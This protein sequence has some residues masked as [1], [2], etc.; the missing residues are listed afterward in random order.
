LGEIKKPYVPPVWLTKPDPKPLL[1]RQ[2]HRQPPSPLVLA[3]RRWYQ[4]WR[5]RDWDAANDF[6]KAT[7]PD[8]Q[9][10]HPI[11]RLLDNP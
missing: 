4:E 2:R 3:T 1:L 8:E 6:F 7:D 10:A 9:F 11:I 5:N